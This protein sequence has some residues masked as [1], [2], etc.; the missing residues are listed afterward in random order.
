MLSPQVV[1]LVFWLLVIL[2]GAF[3]MRMACSLFQADIP[4]WR[5][6]VISVVVVTFLAYLTFDFTAY[7]IMRSMQ[8]VV[9]PVPPGYGYNFWFR[10]AI[11]FKWM[12]ISLAGPLRYLPII[13]AFCV[14]GML[15]VVVMQA[16]VTFRWGLLIFVVQ[17]GAT[18]AAAYVLSLVFGFALDAI[19]WT[20]QPVTVPPSSAHAQGQTSPKDGGGKFAKTKDKTS[21][22][23]TSGKSSAV[24]SAK[25]PSG[26][27]GPAG[28]SSLQAP[29]PNAAGQQEKPM[30]SVKEAAQNLKNYAD[31]LLEEVKEELEPVTKHL[32]QP[33]NDFL[34]GGG[35]WLVFG[36]VGVIALL[37]LR[38]M[39]RKL[40][41]AMTLPRKKRKRGPK[42]RSIA[43]NLKESLALIGEA[44][45]EEGP[46]RITVNSVLAR[47]RLVVLSVGAKNAGELH[48]EMADRVLDWIK[49]GLAHAA[50]P[51]YPAVRVWPPF[52]SSGA[53]AHAV[54]ANVV[55]PEKPGEQ[56]PWVVLIGQVKV[57][58][59]LI[60][61]ALGLHADEPHTM[62]IIKVA[63]NQW[64]GVLGVQKPR[65]PALA[66]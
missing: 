50:S 62:R 49:P 59:A 64:L 9:F 33:I 31:S 60:N 36:V 48:K 6:A 26:N 17:F 23:K 51:D 21:G 14:A 54:Q 30:A 53:F 5:R 19:G 12:I 24:A 34:D 10:E 47:L 40:R 44:M 4:S 57:G 65:Q 8:D 32:P 56:S 15:Q 39:V 2:I 37:W 16:E 58:Q 25:G 61:V 55:F 18:A 42:T 1:L 35:W 27:K 3:C 46:E 38:A 41:G 66:R 7:L 63:G 29:E 45:T 52:F 28:P 13:F 20:P 22:K 11:G 43:I